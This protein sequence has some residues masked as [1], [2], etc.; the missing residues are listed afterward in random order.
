LL[1]STEQLLTLDGVWKDISSLPRRGVFQGYVR[2][3]TLGVVDVMEGSNGS[4]SV[5]GILNQ[6]RISMAVFCYQGNIAV[7][8][9]TLLQQ[10]TYSFLILLREGVWI[11]DSIY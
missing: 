11:G 9:P 10:R 6:L 4:P 1:T 5:C 3:C 7:I 8:S 2:C